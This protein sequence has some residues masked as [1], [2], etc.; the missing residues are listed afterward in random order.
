M[1]ALEAIKES[2]GAVG[3]V[4]APPSLNVGAIRERVTIIAQGV[5]E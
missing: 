4:L 5:G 2:M 3:D 1:K